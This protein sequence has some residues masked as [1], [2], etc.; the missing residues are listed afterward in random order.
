MQAFG[1]QPN[2]IL[3]KVSGQCYLRLRK[4][5]L[6]LMITACLE[7]GTRNKAQGA[8]DGSDALLARI[9]FG[10]FHA[11]PRSKNVHC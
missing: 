11:Q 9:W 5:I 6:M 10:C 4:D 2:S 1:N 3:V 7:K 8:S